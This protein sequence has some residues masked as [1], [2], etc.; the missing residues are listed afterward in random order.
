MGRTFP[1]PGDWLGCL[2]YGS[3]IAALVL[4]VLFVASPLDSV[5]GVA[6]ATLFA[7]LTSAVAIGLWR[8]RT[9]RDGEHLGTADDVTYDPIADPGQAAKHRW[10][11]AARRLPGD[12]DDED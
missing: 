1:I 11:K 8:W 4:V 5:A 7:L 9:D 12:E 2:L 6:L 10:Q 3:Q